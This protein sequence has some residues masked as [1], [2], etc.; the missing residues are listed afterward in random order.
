MDLGKLHAKKQRWAT[1]HSSSAPNSLRQ[2]MRT[3]DHLETA[4]ETPINTVDDVQKKNLFGPPSLTKLDSVYNMVISKHSFTLSEYNEAFKKLELLQADVHQ[5]EDKAAKKPTE[6]AEGQTKTSKDQLEKETGKNSYMESGRKD[7]AT[8]SIDNLDHIISMIA[9]STMEGSL[10]VDTS[11]RVEGQV[12]RASNIE[13]Q[14]DKNTEFFVLSIGED[15]EIIMKKSEPPEENGDASVD[16]GGDASCASGAVGAG[17]VGDDTVIIIDKS[18][19][20]QEDGDASVDAGGAGNVGEDTNIIIKKSESPWEDDNASV[21]VGGDASC[22]GGAIGVGEDMKMIIEKTQPPQED[23]DAFVDAGGDASCANGAVGVGG[24]GG[25]ASCTV[26]AIGAGG[27]EYVRHNDGTVSQQREDGGGAGGV[28]GYVRNNDGMMS[29]PWEDPGNIFFESKPSLILDINGGLLSLVDKWYR[30]QMPTCWNDL[31]ILD[32]AGV[33]AGYKKD[34][35]AFLDLCLVHFDVFVWICWMKNKAEKMLRACFPDH[36]CQFK[37]I[38]AQQDC[39]RDARFKIIGGK[40]VFY[41]KL[42]DFWEKRCQ[43]TATS[44]ILVDDTQ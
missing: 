11:F 44:T 20:S 22:A 42:S 3:L 41:K 28:A 5:K 29:R 24:S 18:E 36:F 6:D 38:I 12:P 1:F 34:A 2:M 30:S 17:G 35:P 37:E 32:R 9:K 8:S 16:A 33:F 15:T 23:G 39:V 7:D 25:D 4:Q 14:E 43:Y 26:D 13:D 31:E 27:V 40:P 21:D 10:D 19:P